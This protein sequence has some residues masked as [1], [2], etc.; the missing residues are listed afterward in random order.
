MKNILL[1]GAVMNFV[2]CIGMLLSMR[3]KLPFSFPSLPQTK[4]INPPDYVLHRLFSAGTVLIFGI[5]FVY[6]YYHSEYV[7]PFLIFGVALK[8]W[9]FIASLIS[10]L[11]FKMPKDVLLC[12]GVPSL[13]IAMLFSY[14]LLNI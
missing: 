1:I 2:G 11:I 7:M 9:V 4:D 3:F 5:M 8:L 12:F 14:Y 10:Y 6:L 13:A